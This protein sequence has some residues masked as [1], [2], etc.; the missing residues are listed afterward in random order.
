M[1]EAGRLRAQAVRSRAT[2][3]QYATRPYG[4]VTTSVNPETDE[5][6]YTGPRAG[7]TAP[8]SHPYLGPSSWIRVM[9]ERS[10]RMILDSRVDTGETFTSAYMAEAGAGKL[11]RA[12]YE[13]SRFYYRRLR[14]GEI[15]ITSTGLASAHFGSDGTLS[16]RGGPVTQVL[17]TPN[18]ELNQKAPTV[19]QRSL[20]NSTTRFGV[21]KRRTE[22]DQP[23]DV[24]IR[25][26]PDG[27]DE[28]FAKEYMRVLTSKSSP[29][30]L[31]DHREGHV[32]ADDG[33]EPTSSVTGKK[34]R[35]QTK[36]GTSNREESVLEVDIEGNMNVSLSDSSSYGINVQVSRTDI[37][38]VA[39]RDVAVTVDRNFL[40]DAEQ[41]VEF[42]ANRIKSGRNATDPM[43][44]GDEMRSW[45]RNA[46]VLTAM[47]P[48]R[49]LSTDVEVAFTQV[50]STKSFVE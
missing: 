28:V 48:A 19:I 6:T 39:G 7:R 49:F 33:T 21:V 12:T 15:D 32:V 30:S 26:T 38:L 46:V 16:L 1:S 29:F 40:V 47:G 31:V 41:T 9:P 3:S 34:L 43:L 13:D 10:T 25:I 45:L 35:S 11:I 50:L 24:W 17:D 8:I 14:E 22:E 42:E 2:E 20:D 4:V 5:F 23:Q 18:L 36:Y 27:G 44:L 37:K